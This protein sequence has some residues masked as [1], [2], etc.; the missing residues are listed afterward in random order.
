[1][2]FDPDTARYAYGT[3]KR[4]HLHHPHLICTDVGATVAFYRQW[5]DAEVIWD[6]PYAGTRNVFLKIGIGALHLYEKQIDSKPRNALHHL[7]VQVVG[8]QDI[9]ERMKAAGLHI[10]NGIRPSDGGGYFMVEAPDHVLLEVFEPGP[11][12]PEKI[13]TYYGLPANET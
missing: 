4:Y 11:E 8:L 6:G 3:H 9:F 7:G 12:R 13:L 1:M 2:S 10:P 5:F